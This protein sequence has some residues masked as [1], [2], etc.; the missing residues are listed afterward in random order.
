MVF[1]NRFIYSGFIAFSL[2]NDVLI[3]LH[4][5]GLGGKIIRVNNLQ[6]LFLATMRFEIKTLW[7]LIPNMKEKTAKTLSSQA[8]KRATR[9]RLKKVFS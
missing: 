9:F 7:I 4:I 1:L 2:L 5:K 6:G 8:Y 3:V